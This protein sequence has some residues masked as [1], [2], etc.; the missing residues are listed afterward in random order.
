MVD[1]QVT[2]TG[3]PLTSWDQVDWSRVDK[4]VRRLRRR[5]FAASQRKNWKAL[6]GLQKLMLSCMANVLWA[7]RQVTQVN[8]GRFTPGI[9]HAIIFDDQTRVAVANWLAEV[10]PGKVKAKPV[11]RVYIPKKNGKRRPLGIPVII[12]RIVQAVVKNALEPEWEA[13]FAPDTYGFRPGRGAHDAID[14]IWMR[15]NGKNLRLWVLDADLKAAFDHVDHDFLLNQLAGFP[16]KPLIAKWLKAGVIEN[17]LLTP[18]LEG[19]PQGGVISPLL[20]SI[21]MHGLEQAAGVER[22]PKGTKK[23]QVRSGLPVV[24]TYADDLVCLCYSRQQAEQVKTRLTGWLAAR[25]LAFNEDKTRIVNIKDGFDF[26]GFN[27]RKYS[28]QKTIIKPSHD[29]IVRIRQRLRG[30]VK[31]CHGANAAVIIAKLG[32]IIKG[33]A[34]Y[35]H[36]VVSKATFAGLDHYLFWLLFG[37]AKRAHPTKPVQWRNQRY[38]GQFCSTRQDR[39]VFGDQTTGYYLRRFE[40]TPIKRHVKVE[41]RASPDDPALIDYWNTRHGHIPTPI[42]GWTRHLL[43]TQQGYCP[44]C[45]QLLLYADAPPSTASEWEQWYKSIKIARRKNGLVLTD[46]PNTRPQLIHTKCTPVKPC[47]PLEL[48]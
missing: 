22:Y 18:T 44:K 2:R 38:F 27:I 30:E 41:G 7:I 26:L 1:T 31:A 10:L 4:E 29:A 42:Q 34:S 13:R 14:A 19:V 23:D 43:S 33:W 37:W 24:I 45:G 36:T 9:D 28:N 46:E 8:Q 20:L 17:G 3:G 39:W 12:D 48:A 11:R 6:K 47:S 16:A 40:W 5:I 25:G 21:T 35:Y 15:T 32:P